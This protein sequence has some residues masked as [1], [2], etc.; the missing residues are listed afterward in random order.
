MNKTK[1][2]ACKNFTGT[3]GKRIAQTRS[4]RGKA[5]RTKFTEK[6]KT[7]AFKKKLYGGKGKSTTEPNSRAC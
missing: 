1:T 6:S 3:E 5:R 7:Q 4:L 2:Q